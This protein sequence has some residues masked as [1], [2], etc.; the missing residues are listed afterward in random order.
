MLD[1]KTQLDIRIIDSAGKAHWT[2]DAELP[3]FKGHFPNNPILPGVAI[4]DA[5]IETLRRA[6]HLDGLTV[7]CIKSCKFMS[8]VLPNC[9]VEIAF[10]Q[11]QKDEWQFEWRHAN[12]DETRPLLAL[13]T[14]VVA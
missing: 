5:S 12:A 1:P 2:P 14:F 7:T 8:P 4:I 6:L 3:Y 13:V 11:L 10:K 9:T